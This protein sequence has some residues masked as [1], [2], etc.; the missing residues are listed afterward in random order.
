MDEQLNDRLSQPASIDHT[1]YKR[2]A[3]YEVV[4][5]GFFDSNDDG[6]GDIQGITAKLDYLQWLGVDCLWLLPFMDSPLRDGGYDI[7]D[8]YTVLPEYGTVED[9]RELIDEVHKR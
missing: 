9:M 6:T 5:R 7:S 1:W 2:A 4:T 3:F 8:Y